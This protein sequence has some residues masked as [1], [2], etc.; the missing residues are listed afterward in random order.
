M[1]PE[2]AIIGAGISGLSVA[3][4]LKRAGVRVLLLEAGE[5]VGGTMRSRR[6]NGYLV[7]LG[8]NSALETTPLFQ[9]LIAAVGLAGERVY[10]SEAAR[11]RYIFRD[12][13]LHPLPLTPL[14]FL[15]SRLW[16][17]KG[18][19][20]VLAE[21]FHGRADREESVADFVRRRVGQEFLDYAVNPFVAGIYAGDP[22]RLS[23]RFAFPRLYALEAQY[24]GLFL[25]MLRGARERRR[26]REAAKIAARL[27]SFR[28]GMGALPRALAVALGD[29]V[30][31]ATRALCVE[32]IGA[33]F[34]IAFERDGRR[35]ALRAERV[36]LA[37]PAYAAAPLVER[38]APEAARALERIVYPPVSTV[39]LGYPESAIGRPLD[40]F[41]FLVPEKEQRRILGTIWNS[42]LFPARAPEGFVTLTTFV[43][44]MRQPELARRPTEELIALVAEELA[45]ILRLRGEPDFASVSRWERAIPQYELGYGEILDAL[46]RAE[47]EHAGLY[48]CANYRGGIA[49]GDCVKSARETAER[50]LRDRARS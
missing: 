26:R 32:R 30:W 18:K 41:G 35:D 22:E 25:G 28:E 21:P 27:F 7:E 42:T 47:R 2:V 19:L 39:V 45:D 34:E 20:R 16:S 5:D 12:G 43:G 36:V 44:G 15:R 6:C 24:G 1:G 31:C 48:F 3:F 10:A 40:G 23:V 13:E 8:P 46:D 11:N 17:W 9:E 14:A 33:T 38:L 4:F 50:I 37:T 29:T 49:V